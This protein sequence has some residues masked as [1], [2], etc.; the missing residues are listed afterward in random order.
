M[1]AIE[2]TGLVQSYGS[3]DAVKGIDLAVEAGEI[4]A[5]L[6]PN[7]AGKTTT[8]EVLEGFRSPTRGGVKVLGLD[9]VVDGKSLRQR[10]GIVLQEGGLFPEMTVRETLDSWRRFYHEPTATSD[11]M[12]R[13]DLTARADVRVKDLSGGERRRL[14][15]ALGTMHRPE[16][17]FLDEPTT[18][19][20]P[21]ARRHA[22]ELIRSMAA[23]G[24]TV[25]LTTHYLE[26]AEYLA[27][28]VAVIAGGRIIA[29]GT[30][31]SLKSSRGIGVVSFRLPDGVPFAGLPTVPNTLVAMNGATVEF[32]TEQLTAAT[33]AITGW[34]IDQRI[35]LDS[36][37]VHRPSLEDVY[38][39]LI[40]VNAEAS[41]DSG[42]AQ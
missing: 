32:R 5:F 41:G 9:P 16:V 25:F 30:P 11:A 42:D 26:E 7:G 21:G 39:E 17:L 20:D 6:G 36:L 1:I 2:A 19:F 8:V 24:T 18:G 37:A 4:F 27:D 23:G 28:R 22:W 15:L 40:H 13:V 35:E 14:D 10:I 29:S 38:L 3:F 12:A 33:H 34:A 31:D